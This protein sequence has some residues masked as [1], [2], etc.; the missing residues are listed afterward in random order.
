MT[1]AKYSKEQYLEWYKSMETMREFE[2]K[3]GM[4]FGQQKIRGFCHLYT[5]QEAVVAGTMSAIEKDDKIITAYRDHAHAIACGIEPKY[6]M[7][8]LFGKI[9]GCSKGKGGSMHMFSKEHNFFGGHGIV[10]AQVPLGAGI[11]FAEKYN[12]T[13][14]VC[15][16]YMGDGA[17]L[18]GAVYES[19]N[20]AMTWKIPVVF[21]IENNKYG[22]GTDIS[23][24]TNTP[25]LYKKACASEMPAE[26]VDGMN[27]EAVHEAMTKAC[28]SARE[29]HT[30]YLLEMMTYRY[31]GHSMSD[32]A[33][34]RSKEEVDDFKS[35]DPIEQV[36][37]TMLKH[38]FATED[39]FK[40][41]KKDTQKL[42]KEA[43]DFA[44]NSEYPAVEE[45]YKDVYMQKDYPFLKDEY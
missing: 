36:K 44:E 27:V 6:V 33:K 24:V 30:P 45:L 18:Q 8:E 7:A 13:N 39:D 40:Q 15:I 43:I 34:Y 3:A 23:R 38:K 11:A 25:D 21:V 16:T 1:K 17:A 37:A 2:V 32:P 5:G 29:E 42:I 19:F 9:D 14:K 22:M 41:N 26:Q 35:K 28:K 12:E 31:K 10:G 4:L 20:L